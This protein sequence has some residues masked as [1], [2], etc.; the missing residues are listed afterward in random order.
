MR[1]DLILISTHGQMI[2]LPMD[3]VPNSGR[4]TQGVYV[5]RMNEGDKVASL[6]LLVDDTLPADIGKQELPLKK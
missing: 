4:A 2:R 3:Q 5:M 1:G 6:S